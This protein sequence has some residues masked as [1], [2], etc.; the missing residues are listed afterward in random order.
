MSFIDVVGMTWSPFSVGPR[1]E[2]PIVSVHFYIRLMLRQ[3][4][5]LQR[6][7][8]RWILHTYSCIILH[9]VGFWL[10]PVCCTVSMRSPKLG[11]GRNR[12]SYSPILRSASGLLFSFVQHFHKDWQTGIPMLLPLLPHAATCFFISQQ[13]DPGSSGAQHDQLRSAARS[14]GGRPADAMGRL[15]L[16]GNALHLDHHLPGTLTVWFLHAEGCGINSG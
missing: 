8:M 7:S 1:R 10:I 14:M 15:S 9:Y 4:L 13:V 6:K 3:R 5:C 16:W 11:P 2:W 12:R